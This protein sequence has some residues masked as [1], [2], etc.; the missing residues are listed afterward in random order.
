MALS[1]TTERYGSV[2]KTFHWLMALLIFSLI[3]MGW[4]AERLPYETDA[5]LA[6]KAW[7]FSMHKTFGVLA[8]FVAL[9]RI[10]WALSQRK[11]GL[12]NSDRRLESFAAETV[13][14]LLYG[15]LVIVPLSGWISHAAASGF[16]PIWWPFGQSLPLVPKSVQVE[17]A[18]S[19][20]HWISGQI[21]VLS[22]LFHVAGAIKHHVI[23][24]DCTL[25]RMAPGIWPVETPPAAV[26]RQTPLASGVAIWGIALFAGVSIA[27]NDAETAVAPEVTLAKVT[28]DWI[29]ETG[30][31]D[32]TVLQLGSEVK[33][34]F[35]DW[36]AAISF[37]ET[38]PR[39]EVGSVT[40]TIAIPSLSLGSVT[41]Q[42]MGTDFFDAANHA[43]AVFDAKIM[44]DPETG[45][46]AA[47]TLNIKGAEVPLEL[48]FDLLIEE[49][50]ADMI[51][52]VTLNRMDFGIGNSMQDEGSL[53]FAVTV[54]I[55]LRANNRPMS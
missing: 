5:E 9:L 22:I 37:D 36:T 26:H 48:P 55:T 2:T 1:N 33:G 42:A 45:Y 4:Y 14:W 21:L 20:V 30:S 3:G 40:A 34:S 50:T 53:G 25:R 51:G 44:R 19:V 11:P 13:H 32:I 16:A 10:F 6:R 17:H 31:I 28:S 7:F 54:D 27:N 18:F 49:G 47:G 24:R 8:F 12:I 15:A 43:T 29:V 46:T 39:G 38:A 41:D 35:A 23:D 52:T